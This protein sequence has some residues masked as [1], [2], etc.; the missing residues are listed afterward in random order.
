MPSGTPPNGRILRIDLTNERTWV[1]HPPQTFFYQYLGGAI[2]A[3]YL[4]TLSRA[5]IDP[6]GPENVITFIPG[7]LAHLAVGAFNRVAITAKSPMTGAIIDAQ[8]GGYWGPECKMAGFDAVVIQGRA[9][10]PVY[11]IIKDGEAQIHD[12]SALW[13]LETGPAEDRIKSAEGDN[14]LRTCIIGPAGENLVRYANI[15]NSLRHF[16][17]RGGLGAVM[18][19]KNLKAVAVRSTQATM[20]LLHNREQTLALLKQVNQSYAEDEFFDLVLTPHGTPWAIWYNQSKGRLPT[21]NF[22]AGFFEGADR[23]NHHVLST[24]PMTQA[25]ENCFACRVRCKRSIEYQGED[26]QIEKRYGGA[27]YETLGNLGPLLGIDDIV[28]LEKAN[29]LCSK[30]TLD[31]IS[32]GA[33]IAWAIDCY[34]N[35]LIAKQDTG[36]LELSWGDAA[37][38]LEMIEMVARRR[39]FGDLLAEGSQRAAQRFGAEAEALAAHNKGLEWPAVDPRPDP[40]Q[41]IAYA[42]S[43]TGADHMT[44][45]GPDCGPEFWEMEPPPNGKDL[46]DRLVSSYY[47][48]RTAGSLIDGFGICRFLAG[49][50][51]LRRT[52]EIIQAA[53]GWET[54]LWELMR[55]GDRRI[56]LFR[57][58]NAREGLTIEQDRMPERAFMPLQA[59]PEHGA[60]L[61]PELH[62]QAVRAYYELSGWDPESGWPRR[63]KL[64]ELDLAW[65]MDESLPKPTES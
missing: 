65:M 13:G 25:S 63:G 27:E 24:H 20:P 17:G 8:A 45:A 28:T 61:D 47:L 21:R 10:H 64:L 51:G 37:G 49:A 32:L 26:I 31:T 5:E 40:M 38:L 33:T 60:R 22:E 4:Y 36:G 42:V 43:P 1:D 3:Y 30:Y 29:E 35:G 14:R 23:I 56:N 48:Q 12:A 41:A 18:G 9:A 50:T 34:Q 62:S 2:G 7:F 15:V 55:A 16:A 59:G 39:G 19:S 58:Y 44:M 6:L 57:A 52:L 53:T 11:I 46:G 54:S